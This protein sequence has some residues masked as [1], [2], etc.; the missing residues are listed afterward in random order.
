MR[1]SSNS[2]GG[3]QAASMSR[4]IPDE[5]MMVT[6]AYSCALEKRHHNTSYLEISTRFIGWVSWETDY[7]EGSGLF[8]SRAT[9]GSRC[10]ESH[11][12]AHRPAER[13]TPAGTAA[14]CPRS[15]HTSDKAWRS[16]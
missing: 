2:S 8:D 6:S 5:L 12:T 13:S 10:G 14:A 7:G 4:V 11:D 3:A 16:S 9:S 1:N 15:T